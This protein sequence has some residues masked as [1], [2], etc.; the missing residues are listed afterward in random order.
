VPK[1]FVCQRGEKEETTKKVTTAKLNGIRE[2]EYIMP[3]EI[4]S[5]ILY[6]TIPKG[7]GDVHMGYYATKSGLNAPLWAPWFLLPMVVSH[8]RCVQ[9]GTFMG[10][11]DLS[12]QFLN[13]IHLQP[14]TGVD[15]T[16]YFPEETVNHKRV[17]WELW[18]LCGMGFVSSR[19]YSFLLI[20]A[21]L[22]LHF[23]KVLLSQRN[24]LT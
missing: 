6:F 11:I 12:E 4:R 8:L 15:V 18:T 24:N 21:L 22:N 19:N 13:F 2:N 5:L 17:I 7:D 9:P 14:F 10:D 16:P 23:I 1:Y 20:I 3:V